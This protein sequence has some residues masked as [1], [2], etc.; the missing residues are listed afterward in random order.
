[1]RYLAGYVLWKDDYLLLFVKISNVV[2]K[3]FSLSIYQMG[4]QSF[5]SK[6]PMTEHI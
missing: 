2:I 5:F 4:D 1:M 6:K 3:N